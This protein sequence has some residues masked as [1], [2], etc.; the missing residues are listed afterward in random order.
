MLTRLPR[1]QG[2]LL[3]FVAQFLFGI[4]VAPAV[5]APVLFES[6]SFDLTQ[7]LGEYGE[8]LLGVVRFDWALEEEAWIAGAA[9]LAWAL[10]A[11]A[12]ISPIVGPARPETAGRSL[13]PSVI[14]AVVVG[15]SITTMLFLALVEGALAALSAD[16][17]AF[18]AR[19][20]QVAPWAWL[21]ALVAWCASGAVWAYA[22]RQI[23]R[24]R[25]P[26]RLDRVL[27][28]LFAGTALELVLGIPI[29]LMARK[30]VSCYCGLMTFLNLVMGISALL[31]L[32]GPWAVLLL[33]REARRNWARGAC[34]SCGYLQRSG[35]TVCSECGA[36]LGRP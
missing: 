35:S 24:T 11:V 6:N 26:G 36:A 30:K 27:R 7:A 9:A 21:A 19:I 4:L 22:L 3:V 34:P 15:A 20:E 29:Y 1:W 33:T 2:L 16:D 8:Y 14:A 18:S 28:S 10:L 17:Q 5:F 13:L 31:W 23:G 12:F 32:C 25:D